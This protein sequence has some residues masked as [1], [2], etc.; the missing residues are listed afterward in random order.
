[1]WDREGGTRITAFIGGPR[2]TDMKPATLGGSWDG[3]GHTSDLLPTFCQAAGIWPLPPMQGADGP[4]TPIDGVS[5]WDAIRTNSSSER[6]EVVHMVLN[7]YTH[8]DCNASGHALQNCGASIRVG[9]YKLYAGYP[10]D[11]QWGP[12]PGDDQLQPRILAGLP[13]DYIL[14]PFDACDDVTGVG[15]P[16]WHGYC[17]FN[18]QTDRAER[19]EI[20]ATNPEIVKSLLKRLMQVSETGTQGAYMCAE[21]AAADGKALHEELNRTGAFLPYIDS[22]GNL[23]FPWLNDLTAPVCYNP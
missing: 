22:Q 4:N 20:S 9:D 1:M 5:F 18:V 14:D 16:C 3:L 23:S 10:G 17:L 19:H 21:E 15:C 13:S 11:S 8:R 7:R 12:L 6:K 2:Y